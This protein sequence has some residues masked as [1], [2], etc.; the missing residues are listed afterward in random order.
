M[1][2]IVILHCF[3]WLV[4]LRRVSRRCLGEAMRMEEEHVLCISSIVAPNWF[5]RW[6]MA[7]STHN[8]VGFYVLLQVQY[9]MYSMYLSRSHVLNC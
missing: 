3:S 9:S 4:L 7:N 1:Q 6:Q 2:R 5:R 8:W